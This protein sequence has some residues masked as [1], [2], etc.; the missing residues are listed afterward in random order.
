MLTKYSEPAKK[1]DQPERIVVQLALVDTT[2][3][4]V[5]DYVVQA[6]SRYDRAE[7]LDTFKFCGTHSLIVDL[8]GFVYLYLVVAHVLSPV[9]L[10]L[11]FVQNPW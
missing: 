7:N 1:R 4:G 9:G 2:V 6:T 10:G 3:S 8:S 11:L 5:I